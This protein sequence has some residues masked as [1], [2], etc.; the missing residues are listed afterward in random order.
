MWRTMRMAACALAATLALSGFALAQRDHDYD[1]DDRYG[2]G[3]TGQARQQGY[4]NGY[5]DG[6]DKGRHEGREGDANDYHIP[7]YRQSSRGYRSWMGPLEVYQRGYQNG[8]S[9]GFR[10]GYEQ[11]ARGGRGIDRD[12]GWGN[13]DWGHGGWRTGYD[14]NGSTIANRFGY[15]DGAEAA[16]EDIQH[17]KEYNSKPRGRF[18]DRDHGYRHEFG[19]RDRYKAEYTA[20]YRSGY[21]AIYRRY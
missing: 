8:Y 19:S 18:G 5:R 20:G 1:D 14:P 12:R 17:R 2:Q 15:E 4:Q 3:D 6:V 7:D 9:N 16:R 21:D 13:N 11:V 10:S